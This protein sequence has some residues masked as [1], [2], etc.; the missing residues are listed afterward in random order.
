MLPSEKAGL[1]ADIAVPLVREANNKLFE[2]TRRYPER[3]KGYAQ[4]AMKDVA[5]A[6]E[7]LKRCRNELGFVGLNVLS[8][9][10][11]TQIYDER[12]FRFWK[13]RRNRICL[14]FCIPP[15]QI[16]RSCMGAAEQGCVRY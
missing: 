3:L 10:G 5:A 7:E 11:D 16:Y 13:R 9:Y 6:V 12:Y 14:C 1:E 15:C 2:A 8:N 4:L